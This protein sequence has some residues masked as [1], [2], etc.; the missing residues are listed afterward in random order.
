MMDLENLVNIAK[1]ARKKAYS[2]YSNFQVG[3]ALLCKNGKVYTG[4]NIENGG[5]QATCAERVAFMKAISEGEKDFSCIAVVGG[6]ANENLI[7]TTPCG[8]CRQ[9]MSEFV[10]SDFKIYAFYDNMENLKTYSIEDL[11]PGSFKL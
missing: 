9:F 2:P 11:L 8:Y 7:F 6:H 1:E 5:I 10:D 4:C 3:A